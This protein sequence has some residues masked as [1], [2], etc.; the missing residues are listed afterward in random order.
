MT[1]QAHMIGDTVEWDVWKTVE[2]STPK[3][4]PFIIT[5]RETRAIYEVVRFLVRKIHD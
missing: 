4:Q 1:D 2:V 3:S 5:E